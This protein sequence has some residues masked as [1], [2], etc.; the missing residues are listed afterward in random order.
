MP[1]SAQ[2]LARAVL[3]R[4]PTSSLSPDRVAIGAWEMPIFVPPCPAPCMAGQPLLPRSDHQPSLFRA[5]RHTERGHAMRRAL[6][7]LSSAT[8][9]LAVAIGHPMAA[10]P[11]PPAEGPL[12]IEHRGALRRPPRAHACR[13]RARDRPG[14]RLH[15]AR[16]GHDQG[17][18]AD[19]PTRGRDRHHHRRRGKILRPEDDAG[20]RRQGNR[21]LVRRGLH[22]GPP[23]PTNRMISTQ[24]ARRT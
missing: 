24:P 12:V 15:G 14:C 13:L 23:T 16:L 17:Q 7:A 1:R 2:R 21:G 4:V 10:Q 11:A 5:S 3:R 8:A 19:R 9:D 6:L 20:G 18:A 22:P